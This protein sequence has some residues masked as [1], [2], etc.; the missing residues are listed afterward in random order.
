MW[1]IRQVFREKNIHNR[2]RYPL[3][4]KKGVEEKRT[5]GS[6]GRKETEDK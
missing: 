3:S 6:K 4:E 1:N 5:K 2:L